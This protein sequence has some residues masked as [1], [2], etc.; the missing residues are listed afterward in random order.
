M[1]RKRHGRI[2]PSAIVEF[3]LLDREFPRA[4]QYCLMRG[5]RVGAR[6]LRHAGRRCSATGRA[7][8]RGALLASSPTRASTTS[9]RPGCTSISIGCRRRMNQVG[10]GI[11]ETFFAASGRARRGRGAN[12]RLAG[13]ADDAVDVDRRHSYTSTSHVWIRSHGHSRRSA[14]PDASTATTGRSRCRRTS[15]GCGPAP[16]CRTPILSYSLRVE[17]QPHFLNWQQDPHG[18]YLARAGLPGADAELRVEVDLVAEMT[19]YQPVRFLPRA[20]GRA[21]SVRLRAVRC[22][23]ELAPFLRGGARGPALRGARQ[24]RRLARRRPHHRL[25]RRAQSPAARARSAT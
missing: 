7:A 4:I 18:N 24:T 5:A 10:N 13:P 20:D 16:H 9:S 25:P 23:S 6:H 22:A 12:P 11:H 21:V 19:V 14:P 1:Y 2:A 15:S 8:A 17:P 3:L